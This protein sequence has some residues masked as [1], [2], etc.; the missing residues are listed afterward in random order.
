MKI[1]HVALITGSI[2]GALT[3]SAV[4]ADEKMSFFITSVGGGKGGDLG[5]LAG[6]DAH[7]GTVTLTLGS[8]CSAISQRCAPSPIAAIGFQP[9]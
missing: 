5:G 9:R 4:A 2:V 8:S 6:A 1:I 7:C 3:A